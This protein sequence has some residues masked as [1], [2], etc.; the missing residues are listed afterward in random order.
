VSAPDWLYRAP[1]GLG[2]IVL[3]VAVVEE[4]RMWIPV[5]IVFELLMIVILVAETVH[6]F[7]HM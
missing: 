5:L 6:T 4:R 1:E 3:L 2:W 7:R